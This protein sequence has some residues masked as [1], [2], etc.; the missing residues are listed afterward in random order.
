MPASQA[1]HAHAGDFAVEVERVHVRHARH[2]VEH[3]HQPPVVG[4]RVGLVLLRD[5]HEQLFGIGFRGGNADAVAPGDIGQ[6]LSRM[7]G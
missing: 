1:R 6:M 5:A 4:G 3:R 7:Y 2:V